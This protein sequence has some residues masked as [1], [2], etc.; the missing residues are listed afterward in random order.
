LSPLDNPIL[1]AFC[2]CPSPQ[3]SPQRGEDV[4]CQTPPKRA[5]D[6]VEGD[7]F[8]LSSNK[9]VMPLRGTKKHESCLFISP[10]PPWGEGWGEGE[11]I[12]KKTPQHG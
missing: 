3:S 10:S 9:I 1:V 2:Q 7:N 4:I 5:E 11:I 8:G 12:I 6:Q